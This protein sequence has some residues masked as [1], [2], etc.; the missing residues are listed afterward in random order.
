MSFIA[1]PNALYSQLQLSCQNVE[2]KFNARRDRPEP[3]EEGRA[4]PKSLGCSRQLRTATY[5]P[6]LPVAAVSRHIPSFSNLHC[7]IAWQS[8]TKSDLKY[9]DDPCY[10]QRKATQTHHDNGSEPCV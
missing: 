9:R 3:A 4:A 5:V 7:A 1:Q 2:H 8:N 10:S 6:G